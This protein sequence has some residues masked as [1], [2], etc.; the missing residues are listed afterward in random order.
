MALIQSLLQR[1]RP[2]GV[3]QVIYQSDVIAGIDGKSIDELYAEQPHLQ[4]VVDFI[5]QN[6]AQL[7]LKCFMRKDDTD[8]VRDTEGVLPR[9]LA[10]PNPDMTEFDLIYSSVAEWALYGRS[11]WLV[12]RDNNSDS[13]WQIRPIPAA[14]VTGWEGSNGF[15]HETIRFQDPDNPSGIVE[16]STADCVIFSK[17]RPGHPASALSPVESLK[18]TLA[19]QAEAQQFRR[20][21]WQNSALVSNYITR[22]KDAPWDAAAAER[23]KSDIRENWRKGGA[24]AGGTPILEDG[25]ELKTVDFN[26]REKDWASGVKLSREDCA[27]AYHINPSIIW[28]GDG[29]TY[30]SA[31]DNA[32]ALYA[33]TLAPLLTMFQKR[34]NKCLAP[35]VGAPES[36]YVEFDINAKLMGSFEEQATALQS[37]VGGPWMTRE[38]A[39]ALRNLPKE[40]Q[41]ELITPLN[42]LVGG[43]ASPN[44]TAPK[45]GLQY[46]T[47]PF[48]VPHP[49][50]DSGTCDCPSCVSLRKDSIPEG[51]KSTPTVDA[52]KM[53]SLEN[54]LKSFFARQR[55]AVL[56]KMGAD[57]KS[58]KADGDPVWWDKDRWT[59]EL[60]DD[61][62]WDIETCYDEGAKQ[63]IMDLGLDPT[64]YD[65]ARTRN[66]LYA[67]ARTRANLINDQTLRSLQKAL[68]ALTA[69]DR[70]KLVLDVFDYAEETRA[71]EQS[72]VLAQTANNFGGLEAAKQ[73]GSKA[74]KTW[75]HNPSKY[76][77]PNHMAMAGETVGVNERFSNGAMCPGDAS[78]LP[79]D[80][81]AH[82]HCTLTYT[83]EIS[84]EWLTQL[85]IE[86]LNG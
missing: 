76:P 79:A 55:K 29:Q 2:Y 13:G 69:E 56:S 22:P 67:F 78:A 8:R 37:A 61:L 27:A 57:V 30:A 60:A 34:I 47:D 42:V 58:L 80:E 64:L 84:D 85:A 32:R 51:R 17:Y 70:H 73:C 74:K 6:V 81:V 66:F 7:P 26:S 14:W 86:A 35:M 1:L 77:R 75:V 36:E 38:E 65:T 4:T 49:L 63:V 28:P 24:H 68:E 18:Q 82:C 5:A 31:K 62:A 21:V 48:K 20:Y 3:Q 11:I 52:S 53:K 16:V 54:T 46:V 50:A 33:D 25:M 71:E 45:S 12:G 19:E 40:P 9:L 15:T 10:N 41:G 43:L 72:R 44:D 39:R 59:R 23:F 83:T